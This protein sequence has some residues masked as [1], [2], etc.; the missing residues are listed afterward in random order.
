MVMNFSNICLAVA[1]SGALICVVL[2][3]VFLVKNR[4]STAQS[5]NA[6][7]RNS[8]ALDRA[9]RD[10]R[11]D[12]EITRRALDE[13]IGRFRKEITEQNSSAATTLNN[14]LATRSRELGE[15]LHSRFSSFT[16]TL[17]SAAK[18]QADALGVFRE[19]QEKTAGENREA[20]ERALEKLRE[21]NSK[22]LD[23]M[24]GIV[25]EK[26]QS[27]LE[28]RLGESFKQVSERL[29][30]VYKSLGEMQAVSETVV[31]L[32][33]VLTNVKTRGTWGEVQLGNLLGDFLAP[34]QYVKNFKPGNGREVVEF[35][36]KLPGGGEEADAPLYLPIDSKFPIEDYRRIT[37]AAEK[38]D[39]DALES[40]S[41]AFAAKI[42]KF[43]GDIKDKYIKPPKTTNFAVLFV[44]TDGI[45]A[46]ILRREGLAEKIQ[47][48][49]NVLIAGPTTL[50]ALVNSLKAGFQ[51]LA[52]Q[53]NSVKIGKT[54]IKIKKDFEKFG[55]TLGK[56]S[57]KLSE[58][59]NTVNDV[60][61]QHQKATNDLYRAESLELVPA[62]ERDD[63]PV[64]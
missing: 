23:E 56:L 20:L 63:A 21:E 55:E 11:G 50:A 28:K 51:T 15:T 62:E 5:I 26:L 8:E 40:A 60:V 1:A 38:A 33:R 46:E 39:S 47:R 22:K 45:Y 64:E 13:S 24:R 34:D 9:V 31:D 37:E 61:V 27:T 57:K 19:T 44:P 35:A 14:T 16:E 36:I 29:E 48:D 32:K 53:K 3:L 17:N 10:I 41:K 43:A 7:K 30:S 2:L 59:Q 4:N 54:L 18:T 6:E 58:A 12:A 52:I 25:D 42:D 49:K